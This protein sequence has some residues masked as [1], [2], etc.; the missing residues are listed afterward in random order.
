MRYY[1]ALIALICVPLR[2]QDPAWPDTYVARLQALALLETFNAE[3]LANRSA[4]A[5]LESWC[6]DHRLA[7]EPKIAAESVKGAGKAPSADTRARLGV[8]APDEVKYRRVRLKCGERVL[9]EADNWY[10]PAR[11]TPE[12]NRTLETTSTPFGRAVQALEPYRRT[13]SVQLLWKPLPDGWERQLPQGAGAGA[14]AIPDAILEH[15]AVLYTRDHRPFSEVHEVY[16]RQLFAF[17]LPA[18]SGMVTPGR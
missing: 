5:V 15:R 10:V 13:V 12:M 16:Q 8:T 9:S 1:L 6:R 3:V 17:P 2:A 11:L 18:H 14:L 4:T 7:A